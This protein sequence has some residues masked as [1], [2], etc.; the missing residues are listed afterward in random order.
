MKMHFAGEIAAGAYFR[1]LEGVGDAKKIR[2]LFR[3]IRQGYG[4]SIR[5]M[6]IVTRCYLWDQFG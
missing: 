6:H 3:K 4:R 1:H 5:A 2:Y